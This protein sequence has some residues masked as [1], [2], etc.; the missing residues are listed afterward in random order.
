MEFNGAGLPSGVYFYK[1][2]AGEF[3]QTKRM[4]LIK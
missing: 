4:V 2:E 3:V 1:L